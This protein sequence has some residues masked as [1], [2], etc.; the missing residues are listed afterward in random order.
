MVGFGSGYFDFDMDIEDDNQYIGNL[1]ECLVVFYKEEDISGIIVDNRIVFVGLI[2]IDFKVER[3][4]E[5]SFC[6][7]C[8]N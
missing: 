7:F 8:G 1:K 5:I 6:I 3:G 2:L 4:F